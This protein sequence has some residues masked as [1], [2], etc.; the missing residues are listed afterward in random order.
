[1]EPKEILEDSEMRM[2][3]SNRS[4]KKEL[5]WHSNRTSQPRVGGFTPRGRLR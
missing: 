5:K 1:M 4:V 2:E 3:K